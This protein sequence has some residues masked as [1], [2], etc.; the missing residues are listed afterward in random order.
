MLCFKGDLTLRY[1]LTELETA[2]RHDLPVVTLVINNGTLAFERHDFVY[3]LGGKGY[4]AADYL[5]TNF[6]KISEAFGC[7]GRRVERPNEINDAVKE[8]LNAG[9][10]AVVDIV[11]DPNE[12]GPVTDYEKYVPRTV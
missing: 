10:P 6:A 4:E 3:F 1:H 9:K 11:T 7:Y 12:I 8:A 5:D 2:R